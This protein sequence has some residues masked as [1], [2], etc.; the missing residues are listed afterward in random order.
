[1][2]T[3]PFTK[4][5]LRHRSFTGYSQVWLAQDHVLVLRSS[6]IKETYR[7]FL[8]A[9]IQAIVITQGPDVSVPR[10]LFGVLIL[11][12][13]LWA[14]TATSIAG[15]VFLG[16]VTVIAAGLLIRDVMRGP[17]CRCVLQTAVSREQVDALSRTREARRFVEQVTPLI[18]QA[19][20]QIVPQERDSTASSETSPMPD[21][22]AQPPAISRRPSF[23]A[24][25]FFGLLFF[26]GI[27]MLAGSSTPLSTV[28]GVLAMVYTAEVVLG[29]LAVAQARSRSSVLW[30]TAIASLVLVGVDA[31][32]LTG[33]SVWREFMSVVALGAGPQALSKQLTLPD[34]ALYLAVGWRIIA[35]AT[36]LFACR[37]DR[38]KEPA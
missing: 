11:I 20:Q 1:M 28:F 8:F 35:C 29:G 10:G 9:D 25:T 26:T 14:I 17:R 16:L 2:S 19:Q 32:F 30:A 37:W 12:G 7:R 38:T 6:R 34:N 33:A 36:G 24:E 21:A 22:A 31:V 3:S 27:L 13:L 23:A 15:K 5:S 18:E 4:A